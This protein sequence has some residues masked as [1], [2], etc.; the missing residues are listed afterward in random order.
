MDGDEQFFSAKSTLTFVRFIA[1]A[2]LILYVLV[3]YSLQELPKLEQLNH[4]VKTTMFKV[5]LCP[6]SPSYVKI[7]HIADI[8]LHSVIVSE[9]AA[10][11]THNG[12]DTHEIK[13]SI[14]KNL[15]AGTFARG[16]S[17][18]TQ[19]LIKN[20]FFDEQKSV[21]RKIKEIY[22]AKELEQHMSKR[23]I[24]ERYL[25]VIEF[26]HGLYGIRAASRHYFNKHPS[27]LNVLE[28]LYL[29]H[30]LPNPKVYS[31]GFL[32]GQLTNY[33][34]DRIVQLLERLNRF[35]RITR[36]QVDL[37]KDRLDQ[38]PWYDLNEFENEMLKSTNRPLF[39]SGT[40]FSTE[41]LQDL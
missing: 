18:I 2:V 30:L 7:D 26:G 9:D 12:V 36:D 16:G 39:S 23:H 5:D 31:Q 17:T 38:F 32:K 14:K 1:A 4:C 3:D 6:G 10:F 21:V 8:F 33:S 37:A 40:D 15:K 34:K 28:S 11:F 13:E 27:Q 35:N 20:V 29:V 19:Q 22:L 41:E 24:L 25:N